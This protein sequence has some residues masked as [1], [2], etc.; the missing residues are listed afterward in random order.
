MESEKLLWLDLYLFLENTSPSAG[1]LSIVSQKSANLQIFTCAH[2]PDQKLWWSL[3][4]QG[5]IRRGKWIQKQLQKLNRNLTC[6]RL[7]V[8]G[9]SSPILPN[10]TAGTTLAVCTCNMQC[11]Y[12][13]FAFMS[14]N[15]CQFENQALLITAEK[16][17]CFSESGAKQHVRGTAVVL[18]LTSHTEAHFGWLSNRPQDKSACSNWIT[19]AKPSHSHIPSFRGV[20]GPCQ[21]HRAPVSRHSPCS[22]WFARGKRGPSFN[23]DF[24][25]LL[26]LPSLSFRQVDVILMSGKE[27]SQSSRITVVISGTTGGVCLWAY[28]CEKCISGC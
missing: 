7:I 10:H 20:T 12:K 27:I 17:R 11:P 1:K 21:L 19:L 2:N 28:A 13:S 3:Q 14:T 26:A 18:C 6:S 22:P 23:L 24:F 4:R 16:G 5:L 8:V 25:F 9:R 15:T